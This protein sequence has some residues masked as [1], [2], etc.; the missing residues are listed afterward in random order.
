MLTDFDFHATNLSGEPKG[1]LYYA[2]LNLIGILRYV[3]GMR[4][5][6]NNNVERVDNSLSNYVYMYRHWH[7]IQ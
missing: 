1:F 2:S 3:C 6:D 5:S 7:L 4:V